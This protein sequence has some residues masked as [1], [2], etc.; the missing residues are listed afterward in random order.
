MQIQRLNHLTFPPATPQVPAGKADTPTP[1]ADRTTALASASPTART[2]PSRPAVVDAKPVAPGVSVDLESSQRAQAAGTYGRDGVL[3]G[4]AKLPADATPAEQFVASAVNT[5]RDFE[6]GKA[7]FP[8][9]EGT[10]AGQA[11][12]Q[13]GMFGGLKQ[14]V[15]RFNLFA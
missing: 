4:K 7:S 3:A 5:L 13:A 12:A 10:A 15:S 14:A 1:A 11:S 6:S 8:S 9:G 2:A